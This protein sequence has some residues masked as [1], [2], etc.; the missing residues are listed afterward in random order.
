MQVFDNVFLV[1]GWKYDF[2]S[3]LRT[4]KNL[5]LTSSYIPK[6]SGNDPYSLETDD[7]NNFFKMN[8]NVSGS[9]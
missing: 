7:G 4:Q 6:Q 8:H 3:F 9:Q 5:V 2:V 1:E